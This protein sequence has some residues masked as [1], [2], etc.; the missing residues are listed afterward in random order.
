MSVDVQFDH[1]ERR[2]FCLADDKIDHPPG[3]PLPAFVLE[4]VELAQIHGAP[5]GEKREKADIP[6][7]RPHE[8]VL[9]AARELP[10]DGGGRLKLFDHVVVLRPADDRVVMLPHDPD[11]QQRHRRDPGLIPRF[12]LHEINVWH[13]II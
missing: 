13:S 9:V 5:S 4:E 2:L 7:V 11:R 10:A 6:A 8:I 1:I 12:Q 3:V